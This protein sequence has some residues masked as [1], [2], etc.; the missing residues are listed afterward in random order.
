MRKL[1][2]VMLLV[3]LG[4]SV[5]AQ[6]MDGDKLHNLTMG[7]ETPHLE[8]AKKLP[9]GKLKALFVVS[10]S[11]ARHVVET[12][13]RMD[14]SLDA[15]T[16]SVRNHRRW[17]GITLNGDG[18][19]GNLFE[20]TSET[21]KGAELAGKL[22]T[23]YEV[24]VLQRLDFNKIPVECK[25]KL[26]LQVKKGSGMLVFDCVNL[27][28][29]L[30]KKPIPDG[31]KEITALAAK[32]LSS[33][34]KAFQFGKGRIVLCGGTGAINIGDNKVTVTG[35]MIPA[36][37]RYSSPRWWA[38]YENGQVFFMRTLLWAADRKPGVKI[39]S[40]A[41]ENNPELPRKSQT[42]PITVTAKKPGDLKLRLRD[43]FNKVVNTVSL[44]YQGNA[45][46]NYQLPI[47]AGGKYFLDLMA[48]GK[49]GTEN[50][51]FY[52]FT[53]KSTIS[54]QLEVISDSVKG[55]EPI[56]ATL[57]LNNP[58]AEGTATI[59]LIDS[60]RE[61]VWYRKEISI[62]GKT[63]IPIVVK[64]YYM[65]NLAAFLRIDIKAGGKP[66]CT[67]D[68]AF[69][70]T[71][72]QQ[73][74]PVFVESHWEYNPGS[75]DLLRS[76]AEGEAMGNS[77]IWV[78][79]DG[80]RPNVQTHML[81]N[82][83]HMTHCASVWLSGKKSK[84]GAFERNLSG[85]KRYFKPGELTKE[86]SRIL[87]RKS[88]TLGDP[89][90]EQANRLAI[91]GVFKNKEL[92]KYPLAAYGMGNEVNVSLDNG[93]TPADNKAFISLL[94]KQFG[95]IAK[96]NSEWGRNY[97]SFKE[98]PRLTVHEAKIKKLYPE[99][100]AQINFVNK[101]VE[102]S[103]R[104]NAEEIKK[105]DP[106]AKIGFDGVWGSMNRGFNTE[107][108]LANK[109]INTWGPYTRLPQL[110]ILRGMRPDMHHV[111][112]WGWIMSNDAL[113]EAPWFNLLIGTCNE[114][115]WFISGASLGG[116]K[117]SA[118][119]RPFRPRMQEELEKL[120]TGPAQLLITT[121][122]KFDGLAIWE[123]YTSMK[124]N[125]LGDPR[126]VQTTD[127]SMPLIDFTYRYGINFKYIVGNTL[128]QLKK[129]R[130]LFLCGTSAIGTPEK[131]VMLEYVRN[132]GVIIADINPG[133]MN[134]SYKILPENR[135][136]EL[137]GKYNPQK[138]PAPA[139]EPLNIGATLNGKKIKFSTSSAM[140]TPGIKPFSVRKYG[141]GQAVLLNFTLGTAKIGAKDGDFD[142][143]MLDLLAACGVK[144][145]IISGNL[146]PNSVV[147][148]RKGDGFELVGITN[149]SMAM[150][151]RDG[152]EMSLTFPSSSYI[153]EVGK[154][155]M[156]QG[157]TG[158]FKFAP[159]FKLLTFFKSEQTA[160]PLKLS[161]STVVP[162]TPVQLDLSPFAKG[163]IMLLQVRD[164]RG[165]LI[166]YRNEAVTHEVFKIDGKRK[167]RPIYFAYTDPKGKYEIML[168]DVATGLK[169]RKIVVLK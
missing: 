103:I 154:G 1:L 45:N 9:G 128:D 38:D 12:A 102:S 133:M 167:N 63:D 61:R 68:K 44:P 39:S 114:I 30:F 71:F 20:G 75:T 127:S 162:G 93:F 94:K 118:D 113:P 32:N 156:A 138:T 41:L 121:P 48:E 87:D 19:Y 92:E 119:Y 46:L 81:L 21:A 85:M 140:V 27:P 37:F 28:G 146:P 60:P 65:P 104:I 76:M 135:L 106:H 115:S 105:R 69:Y 148:V 54:A 79:I 97:S 43:E 136:S 109:N 67:V 90:S 53:V 34:I 15:V 147:R 164:G 18:Y 95:T 137:F 24:I 6:K 4:T 82:Q 11:N 141:K 125:Q 13:Q 8:W 23:T 33:R 107:D 129:Y 151:G 130:V 16:T 17:L 124:A 144:P 158:K 14:S 22:D 36:P 117:L 2:A 3:G 99:W 168:Q 29:G 62:K 100:L 165:K 155:F 78:R 163:R 96:L 145:E 123:D 84:S 10:L 126:F 25:Y 49:T 91:K 35:S 112:V 150:G 149:R 74:L 50:F 26:L 83:R 51:G 101:T 139:S 55:F 5:F 77:G 153:Y 47:L 64:D 59:S 31:S 89:E 66:V 52:A 108:I 152:G 111:T 110:E 56:K 57:K 134:D 160:P 143:F 72:Y 122:L 58:L 166:R 70:F 98:I 42:I 157:K 88:Y 161:S 40:P 80:A 132:G 7:F 169:T 142:K 131:K 120:R 116:Q 86:E 73:H 159:P